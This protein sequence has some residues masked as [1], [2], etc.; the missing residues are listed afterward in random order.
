MKTSIK[1]IDEV[2]HRERI[3][4]ELKKVTLQRLSS[5]IPEGTFIVMDGHPYL[6]SNNCLHRWAPVGYENSIAM[7]EASMV[8]V[9]TP[10]SI[11]NAFRAG[12]VPQLREQ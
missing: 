5:H 2:I 12:F 1:E 8:T 4:S 9:L 7:P 3:D 11:V 6:F 10:S